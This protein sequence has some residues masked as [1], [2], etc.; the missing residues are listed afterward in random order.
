MIA[1]KQIK[2]IQ[3]IVLGVFLV[4][5]LST[6]PMGWWG[7][8]KDYAIKKAQVAR[9]AVASRLPDFSTWKTGA[10]LL[11]EED[12][13][14][15]RREAELKKS[16][17]TSTISP[18]A[19]I[20]QLTRRP[21][22]VP[23]SE[24]HS[25]STT[26]PAPC[27][28]VPVKKKSA[29]KEEYERLKAEFAAKIATIPPVAA[30]GEKDAL[31]LRSNINE[32]IAIL[33]QL[34]DLAYDLGYVAEYNQW[35]IQ[36]ADL[37]EL[38]NSSYAEHTLDW[39]C[40]GLSATSNA[41]SK[42]IDP[43]WAQLVENRK[44]RKND[45]DNRVAGVEGTMVALKNQLNEPDAQKNPHKKI[46]ILND[47][48]DLAAL[49][50]TE[51]PAEIAQINEQ[52]ADIDPNYW[53][54]AHNALVAF[55][56]DAQ[57]YDPVVEKNFLRT[58]PLIMAGY[59]YGLPLVY[60]GLSSLASGG[61]MITGGAAALGAGGML[62]YDPVR[63]T[64]Y[65]KSLELVK[66]PVV[67]KN[68]LKAVPVLVGGYYGLPLLCSGL[69][70]LVSGGLMLAG[71]AA[72]LGA[73]GALVYDPVK[74][75]ELVKNPELRKNL[76]RAVPLMVAGYCSAPLLYSGLWSLASG[77]LALTGGGLM[78]AGST[79]VLGVAGAL[80]YDPVREALVAFAYDKSPEFVKTSL[81]KVETQLKKAESLLSNNNS[82][83]N[84]PR[85]EDVTDQD[86]QI[87][88]DTSVRFVSA[89]AETEKNHRPLGSLTKTR[90]KTQNHRLPARY[91]ALGHHNA[92]ADHG[93]DNQR[94]RQAADN[95][96]VVHI[97]Q[98]NDDDTGAGVGI[99]INRTRNNEQQNSHVPASNQIGG[100]VS[101]TNPNNPTPIVRPAPTG[102]VA[103]TIQPV[104]QLAPIAPANT[105]MAVTGTEFM[106]NH[107]MI[108]AG[109][110]VL[111]TMA[112]TGW[113]FNNK[114][115][116]QIQKLKKLRDDV[117]YIIAQL[118]A[119]NRDVELHALGSCDA[120]PADYQKSLVAAYTA[121]SASIT[122]AQKSMHSRMN[123]GDKRNDH[124]K[125][126][127]MHGLQLQEVQKTG[128]ALQKCI[129]EYLVVVEQPHGGILSRTAALFATMARG[130]KHYGFDMPAQ[131]IGGAFG[132]R[133]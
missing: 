131:L 122:A 35:D 47:L 14:D 75:L 65:N 119:G 132:A 84:G 108:L 69:L 26:S 92:A 59:C 22:P 57:E 128:T 11:I 58:V 9:G 55:K 8:M 56:E 43:Y 32:R 114:Q 80:A 41:V 86:N 38:I 3:H 13:Q 77:G 62:A 115:S 53:Q 74:S 18:Q 107:A 102:P 101:T 125:M 61:L 116:V 36:H 25:I 20:K 90:A 24:S 49:S 113:L 133:A 10:D 99:T 68:L 118:S 17:S 7:N 50:K 123:Q 111:G 5:T 109:G 82:H 103:P 70:P 63:E 40:A 33:A 51:N 124:A 94:V 67:R 88:E 91:T 117:D 79:A 64:L 23:V 95:A 6:M 46:K 85:I 37:S 42:K 81:Q 30:E 19:K 120:L 100:S 89:L 2:H 112:L 31:W 52:L 71:G 1:I 60:S 45:L 98:D 48:R 44:K 21:G 127:V 106:N 66:S 12:M 97:D 126:V 130:V 4:S 83:N 73:G 105:G 54:R 87:R 78:I 93:G 121:F 104:I 72:V 39:I 110:T 76:T 96:R 27:T 29:E 16:A 34:R 15:Q 28:V 129:N